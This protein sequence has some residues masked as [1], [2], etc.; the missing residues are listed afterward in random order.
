MADEFY[1]ESQKHGGVTWRMNQY[2]KY[3][4][5]DRKANMKSIPMPATYKHPGQPALE[6]MLWNKVQETYANGPEKAKE[7]PL[8]NSHLN[9]VPK[10]TA[11]LASG[12][13]D[14]NADKD[15]F[16][17]IRTRQVPVGI[18]WQEDGKWYMRRG[19]AFHHYDF[20]SRKWGTKYSFTIGA[21]DTAFPDVEIINYKP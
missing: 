11:F 14:N 1:H 16:G 12:W 19:F 9:L 21:P 7:N 20:N 17:R 6:K 10:R 2:L 4:A 13:T 5:E 3:E 8:F 18:F 15:A